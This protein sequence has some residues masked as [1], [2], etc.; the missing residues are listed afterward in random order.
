[1]PNIP[2]TYLILEH[3]SLFYNNTQLS[4]IT[5][6]SSARL[7]IQGLHSLGGIAS[8]A[9]LLDYY[10]YAVANSISHSP[11]TSSI[12]FSSLMACLAYQESISGTPTTIHPGDIL[13]V[14]SGYHV[15]YASLSSDD[16]I[17]IGKQ[18]PP[19]TGGVAQEVE[20]LRWLWDNHFAAV[21]GDST[22]FESFP[23]KEEAGFLLHEVLLAGWG[24]PIAEILW[25]EDLAAECAIRKRWTFFVASS[26]L[27]IEGGVASP[28]NMMAIL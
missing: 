15:A 4:A 10:G 25:L 6:P 8:R 1:M 7:G 17:A 13:L 5:S 22:S 23:G 20:L 26:P 18:L 11:L 12:P 16:E 27:N 21:G 28:A 14:R 9:I 24:M 19:V 3:K 2:T